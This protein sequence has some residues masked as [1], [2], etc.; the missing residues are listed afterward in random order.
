MIEIV[1]KAKCCGC[2]ACQQ[3]CPTRCISLLEDREGFLYPA[4]DKATC[5]DCGLCE[6]VCPVINKSS[7]RAPI[8]IYAAKSRDQEVRL[9]SSSGGIFTLL[10]QR[11]IDE[12]GV[13]FGALFDER[14]EVKHAGVERLEQIAEL[15]RS[16]YVQSRIG[17]TF[18]EAKSFLEAGRKV[19][20][21]G[22][23]C[24]IAGLNLF[25]RKEYSNLLTID[26]ACH[27]T[28]SPKVWRLY[29]EELLASHK[30]DLQSLSEISFRDK[31]SGWR[32]YT[33]KI[34]AKA[35]GAADSSIVVKEPA[36]ENVYMNGFLSGLYQR[37]S[38][39]KCPSKM[40]RSGSDITIADYWNIG[41]V[42]PD[43]D[44]QM[45][46]SAVLINSPK[47]A[48]HYPEE[49]TASRPTTFEQCRGENSGF[50]SVQPLHPRRASFF[51]GLDSCGSISEH[52]LYHAP[53]TPRVARIISK[54]K[55]FIGNLLQGEF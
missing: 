42:A 12:G 45:G 18:L 29:L 35:V 39:I 22:T 3:I 8:N 47:G 48:L 37:P 27:G 9:D 23:P 7:R 10:A 5:I 13:V 54:F 38:C 2:G 26:F 49:A 6:A 1:D 11:T 36:A 14:W 32:N 24:Q 53:R 52:I 46:V 41:A 55:A 25:L 20:F 16:K 43:F 51:E 21:V 33:F 15:R 31:E 44:D 4:V 50:K 17:D 19:L 30:A 28:P 34:A 40:G